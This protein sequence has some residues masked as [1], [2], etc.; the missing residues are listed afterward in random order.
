MTQSGLPHWHSAFIYT[1]HCFRDLH[2]KKKLLNKGPAAQKLS[3]AYTVDLSRGHRL[4]LSNWEIEILFRQRRAIRIKYVCLKYNCWGF[5][6][7]SKLKLG[8]QN[9]K[10][11]LLIKET[12]QA[13]LKK[14]PK[15]K[16]FYKWSREYH[17]NSILFS[18]QT[19]RPRLSFE[20][21]TRIF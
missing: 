15:W 13:K 11:D 16:S 20:P 21:K 18:C 14:R 5:K 2:L 9:T 3:Q 1:V 4:G 6:M 10:E 12:M 8:N 19:D 7:P 17:L